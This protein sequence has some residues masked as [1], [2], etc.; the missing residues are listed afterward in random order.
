MIDN[1]KKIAIRIKRKFTTELEIDEL[2]SAGWIGIN[3]SQRKFNPLQNVNAN[4]NKFSFKRIRGAM[5]D[6]IRKTSPLTRTFQKY[7]KKYYAL[8]KK[9]N[10]DLTISEMRKNNFSEDFIFI[11][12]D[13]LCPDSLTENIVCV[14]NFVQDIILKDYVNQLLAILTPEQKRVIE[15]F[16][17]N[18]LKDEEIAD[19]LKCGVT[20]VRILKSKA[21]EKMRKKIYEDG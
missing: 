14:D 2:I 13:F 1:I 9:F 6:E 11:F 10:R 12:R 20:K 19:K 5:I 7:L 4:F 16:Y 18:R 8:R 21:R 15:L 17:F 3:E